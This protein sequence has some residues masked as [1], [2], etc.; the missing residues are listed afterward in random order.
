[1]E[2]FV[3]VKANNHQK[4]KR[5]YTFLTDMINYLQPNSQLVVY[6]TIDRYAIETLA[7]K[8]LQDDTHCRLT[9]PKN[10]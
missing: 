3:N 2:N 5:N 8:Y 7:N 9:L 6:L 4:L 10:A 1:M